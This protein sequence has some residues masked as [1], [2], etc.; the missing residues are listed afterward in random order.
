MVRVTIIYRYE[1][2]VVNNAQK[3]KPAPTN[4]VGRILF[5]YGIAIGNIIYMHV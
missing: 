4:I 2:F 3:K 1:Y 5:V